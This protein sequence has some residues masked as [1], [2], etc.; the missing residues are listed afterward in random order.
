MVAFAQVSR[1]DLSSDLLYPPADR[2]P[3]TAQH[4]A[5]MLSFVNGCD[6][7]VADV[8]STRTGCVDDD[9]DDGDGGDDIARLWRID[10]R[11]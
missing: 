2:R 1:S 4:F 7:M 11:V 10:D 3:Q 6:R 9:D 8:I 5:T